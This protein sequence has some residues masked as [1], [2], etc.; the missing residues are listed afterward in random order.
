MVTGQSVGLCLGLQQSF[1]EQLVVAR[2]SWTGVQGTMTGALILLILHDHHD[3]H[4][5]KME[6]N[7]TWLAVTFLQ[8]LSVFNSVR[9]N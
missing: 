6:V 7:V 3:C 9:S 2:W 8:N 1:P 5:T 4:T